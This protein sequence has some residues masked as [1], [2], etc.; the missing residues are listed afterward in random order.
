MGDIWGLQVCSQYDA[1]A[2]ANIHRIQ[3]RDK[4]SAVG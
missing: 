1:S 4:V 2:S 3:A